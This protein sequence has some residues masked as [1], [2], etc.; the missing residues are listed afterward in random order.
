MTFRY[1]RD[2]VLWIDLERPSREEIHSAAQECGLSALIEEELSNP[3][4]RS[5]TG[6]DTDGVLLVLHLP[7]NGTYKNDLHEQE[8]DIVIGH[9]FILTAH[10]EVIAPLHE[11]QKIMDAGTLAH[12]GGGVKPD[13]LLELLLNHLFAG[14]RDYSSY[15]ENRLTRIEREMF[16][17]K[18]HAHVRQISEI[19]REFLH[20]EA[21]MANQEESLVHFLDEIGHRNFFGPSFK[22]R[23]RRILEEHN[24]IMRLLSTHRAIATE[25]RETNAGII[26]AAQNEIMRRLTIITAL[27]AAALVVFGIFEMNLLGSPF[28]NNPNAFWLVIGAMF[29][30]WIVLALFFKLKKWL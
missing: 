9:H 29:L 10:Y 1:E 21:V 15:I 5:L 28:L 7:T 24:R 11:F 22:S 8:I 4:P 3:T 27:L 23:H 14:T 13:A 19:N 30:V 26:N 12:H 25:L 20:L 18:E 6:N 2:G 16:E 17:G